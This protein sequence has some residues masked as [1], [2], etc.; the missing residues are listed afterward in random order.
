MHLSG[1]ETGTEADA[2]KG[3]VLADMHRLGF[4][5][6]SIHHVEIGRMCNEELT[7]IGRLDELQVF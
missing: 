2:L 1:L 3:R 7:E 5:A 6:L 4:D